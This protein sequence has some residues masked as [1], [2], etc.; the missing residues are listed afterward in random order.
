MCEPRR[1]LARSTGD[2]SHQS[3]RKRATRAK[4]VG[5]LKIRARLCGD[6]G[7]QMGPQLLGARDDSVGR[8]AQ[9]S[10]AASRQP[11]TP[12]PPTTTATATAAA[13]INNNATLAQ[14]R[15]RQRSI[16]RGC[17]Q[18]APARIWAASAAPDLDMLIMRGAHD[19]RRT[20]RHSGSARLA[21]DWLIKAGAATYARAQAQPQA[22]S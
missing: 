21:A 3:S 2:S 4:V 11:P 18:R 9:Q 13:S 7:P 12:A 10:S 6:S 1:A 14:A 15:E 19:E 8:E 22:P 5:A 17:C 20:T 16:Y